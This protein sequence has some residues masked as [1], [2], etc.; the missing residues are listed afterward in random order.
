VR[1]IHKICFFFHVSRTVLRHRTPHCIVICWFIYARYLLLFQVRCLSVH[2]C[3]WFAFHVQGWVE[4]LC[5]FVIYWFLNT[6]F[7]HNPSKKLPA[8]FLYS[9]DYELNNSG[10]ES[11]VGQESSL[12]SKTPQTGWGPSI[13]LLFDGYLGSFPGVKRPVS[14]LQIFCLIFYAHVTMHR[15]KF[16]YNKTN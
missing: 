1:K 5:S 9:I 15:N 14:M 13:S 6:N 16:L 7:S 3:S 4:G 12:F 10:F 2:D 11:R 8:N